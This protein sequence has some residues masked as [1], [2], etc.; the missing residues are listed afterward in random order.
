M[1]CFHLFNVQNQVIYFLGRSLLL[2]LKLSVVTCKK[3]PKLITRPVE[4]ILIDKEKG[5]LDLCFEKVRSKRHC[6]YFRKLI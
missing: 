1:R 2:P 5:V 6:F 3:I 4:S